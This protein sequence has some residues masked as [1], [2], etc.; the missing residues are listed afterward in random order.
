MLKSKNYCISEID[1]LH[2]FDRI[3]GVCCSIFRIL[4]D[5]KS[6]WCS[7]FSDFFRPSCL[8]YSYL[9]GMKC[10]IWLVLFSRCGML[11]FITLCDEKVTLFF[12]TIEKW[13]GTDIME[14]WVLKILKEGY[15]IRTL[16][17]NY[18]CKLSIDIVPSCQ[19]VQKSDIQSQFSMSNKIWIYLN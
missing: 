16:K 5:V 13:K 11:V 6:Q 3:D 10:I 12:I 14:I 18:Y 17:G 9:N 7:D 8:L 1:A 15:K 19:K 4:W 2:I